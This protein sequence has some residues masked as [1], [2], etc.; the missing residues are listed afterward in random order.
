MGSDFNFL[1]YPNSNTLNCITLRG[2]N[3]TNKK[4]KETT[5]RFTNGYF[6][7]SEKR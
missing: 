3:G 4:T 2:K 5:Q 7:K 6:K 1:C